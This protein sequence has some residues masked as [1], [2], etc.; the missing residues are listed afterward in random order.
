MPFSRHIFSKV[1]MSL[2]EVCFAFSLVGMHSATALM[3]VLMKFS[4]LSFI[5]S[6]SDI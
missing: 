3:W 6:V 5:V 4:Y 2:M 1:L